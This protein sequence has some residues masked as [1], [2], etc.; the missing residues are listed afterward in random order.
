MSSQQT[1]HDNLLK[2]RY[3]Y[4]RCYCEHSEAISQNKFIFPQGINWLSR[5]RNIFDLIVKLT[6]SPEIESLVPETV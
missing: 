3:I 1:E 6:E 5:V 2:R 4:I